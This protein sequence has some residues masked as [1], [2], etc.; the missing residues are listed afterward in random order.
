LGEKIDVTID[1]MA[2]ISKEDIEDK[3]EQLRKVLTKRL[4]DWNGDSSV[5]KFYEEDD[6]TIGIPRQFF[7]EHFNLENYNVIDNTVCPPFVWPSIKFPPGMDYRKGQLDSIIEVSEKLKNVNG[8]RLLAKTGS[9]K[10]LMMCDIA[11]RLHTPVLVLVHKLDLLENWK[12]KTLKTFFPGVSVGHVQQSTLDYKSRHISFGTFQT[13]YSKL[14]TLPEDFFQHFGA[15]FID[16]AHRVPASTFEL[17]VRQFFAKYRIGCSATFKRS[18]GLSCVWDWNIGGILSEA[19]TQHLTGEFLQVKYTSVLEL[20]NVG[21][22]NVAK[23]INAIC[24]NPIR[25]HWLVAQMLEAAKAGRKI[26]LLSHRVDHCKQLQ[27]MLFKKSAEIG[28][29]TTVGLYLGGMKQNELNISKQKNIIL[30]T[31][32]MFEEGTDI[33]ELDTLYLASPKKEIEQAVGRIQRPM[34]KRPLLVIDIVDDIN[35]CI[36]LGQER[37]KLF[38]QL[39]FKDYRLR[40]QK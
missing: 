2:W 17:V 11:S 9:G 6:Y 19:K 34:E 4:T 7:V 20:P 23:V 15:I 24:D 18:D 21:R 36:K 22:Y 31:Y 39:G 12:E 35:Y 29:F 3:L 5:V 33:P 10:T 1:R 25:N 16:E 27:S 28:Q 26:A 8:G 14:E 40:E 32:Q 13:I 30:G 37:L 38:E